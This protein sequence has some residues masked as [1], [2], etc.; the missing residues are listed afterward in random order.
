[1]NSNKINHVVVK[2][3]NFYRLRIPYWM[4]YDGFKNDYYAYHADNNT[5]L[6]KHNGILKPRCEPRLQIPVHLVRAMGFKPNEVVTLRILDNEEYS[7][8]KGEV[9]ESEE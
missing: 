6:F 8:T 2:L 1:M 9:N 5:I 3:D 7:I 4:R